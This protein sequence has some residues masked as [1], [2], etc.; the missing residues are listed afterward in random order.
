MKYYIFTI[1]VSFI[2]S[3]EYIGNEACL[4]CHNNPALGDMTGWR[5]TMHANGFSTPLGINS[6][7]DLYG[8]V[9]DANQ[10][11]ID[12]FKDGL[13]LSDP[14]I[15]SSFSDY[16]SNAP[17]LGYNLDNDQYTITIGDLTMPV[18]LMYG[19]SGDYKQRYI[20]KVPIA[21]GTQTISHYVTPVQYNEVTHEYVGYHPEAWYIDPA[22]GDYTPLF[23]ASTVTID[24]IVASA[25]TQKRN[26]EK[27]C[28]GCHFNHTVMTETTEGEW[29]ADA[30][31]AGENDIGSSVYDMDGDGTLDLMNTGCERCHGPGS[32]HSSSGSPLDIIN[33]ANLTSQQANDMC[34]FCHSRGSSYP[35]ETF[36]FP[37]DDE[38]MHDWEVGDSWSDYY[39]DHG[40][41]YN[42][43]NSVGD[44]SEVKSSKKHHQQYFDL[45]ESNKP[46]FV[47][48]EM[49][50]YDCHDVHNTEKHQ[51]RTEIIKTDDDGNELLIATKNDDNTLCLACHA[52]HGDFEALTT[53][54]IAD[55]SSHLTEI[56]SAV[57][58][59]SH[60][61]YDP[62]GSG[63]GK[64]SSCH[65]PKTI[66]SAIHYDI[67]SHTFEAISP[68]KTLLYEMPNSCSV[69]CH[70]EIENSDS[71]LFST[72]AD[73]TLSDWTETSDIDLADT[74]LHYFGP[75][76]IWWEID[77]VL[78]IYETGNGVIPSGYSLS[79]NYPNPFNPE[80]VINFNIIE[81]GN[82]KIIIHDLIGRE[83]GI[84]VD[85]KM[86]S[87]SYKVVFDAGNY[88]SGVY[89]YTIK[90]N[91]FKETKKMILFK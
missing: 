30:P 84:L 34:G 69:S 46:T 51:I 47:Y 33:P 76:G 36:H 2:I 32:S 8:V 43:G 50:C 54:M 3:Q 85:E 83:V 56:A 15:S 24:S 13:S 29:I 38:N 23:S 67:H 26:F 11:G 14:S 59:H 63:E 5:T 1:L 73:L 7:L 82:V 42:D 19:G 75:E 52:S 37:Y 72:G 45:Y 60:H 10:N 4:D 28:V 57:S 48:H 21:D 35:N 86:N 27:Q 25:N 77:Q 74:L 18:M 9:A 65:M 41:Y 87:G 90:S 44:E 78:S 88:S 39:I 79:Q 66:K 20:V 62:E 71:P 22:N 12:D 40:G 61:N 17:I 80:T 55:P 53:D 49:T 91:N 89:L 64:C 16:G 58:G 81:P 31:D 6:M 70:Q 68:Q